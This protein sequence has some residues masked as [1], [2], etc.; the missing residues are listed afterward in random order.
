V[1]QIGLQGSRI[2]ALI[3]QRVAAGMPKHVRV[4]F[5]SDLGFLAGAR[6]QLGKARRGERA[7]FA[8]ELRC[9]RSR[10]TKDGLPTDK[11]RE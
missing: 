9:D 2:E 5:K 11:P 10:T 4:Y 8:D 1:A 3:R 7:A 6:Q